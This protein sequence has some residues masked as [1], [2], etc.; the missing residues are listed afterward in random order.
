MKPRISLTLAAALAAG[1]IPLAFAADDPETYVQEPVASTSRHDGAAADAIAQ[2]LN[3]D[4]SLK[5]AKITV[6]PTEEGIV[7]TGVASTYAQVKRAGEIARAHAPDTPPVN[8][9]LSEEV[10]MWAPPPQDQGEALADESASGSEPATGTEPA[11]STGQPA[12]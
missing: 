5:G 11:T 7:L 2:E 10:L 4:A 6:Q 1:A 9:I 12:S 3:A 8:A